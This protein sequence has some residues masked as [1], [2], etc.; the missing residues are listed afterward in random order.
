[1]VLEELVELQYIGMVHLLEYADFAE[2][3]FLIFLFEVLLV[4]D[5]DCTK[6]IC[7]F[8]ETLSHLT[9]GAC[10]GQLRSQINVTERDQEMLLMLWR[11]CWRS[12][13]QDNLTELDD[14][15]IIVFNISQTLVK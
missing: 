4:D 7:L 8:A 3:L 14:N 13:F 10:T 9:I 12:D 15:D 6:G 5:L 11:D 2:Q 1:M